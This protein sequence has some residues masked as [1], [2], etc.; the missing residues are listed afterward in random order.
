MARN[1]F[2]S[3]RFSDG[4]KYKEE[5]EKLFKDSEDV[6]NYSESEDRSNMSEDTIK[7]YLYG[8]LKNTSVTVILIT[9]NAISHQKNWLGQYDD[10]MYDEIRYSLEDRENNRCNG[11]VA[12]Y[13]DEVK[14]LLITKNTHKCNVCNKETTISSIADV[15]NLFRKN[16]MNVK[17][18]YKTNKCPDVYDSDKDSYCSLVSWDTFITGGNF[19]EYIEKAAQK[20]G[21]VHKYVPVKKL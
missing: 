2:V 15:D 4:A 20:R 11:I 14:D 13:T 7:K 5:L 6:I 18:E 10:W 17:D 19:S 16:M 9:P 1:V 21:E 12:V 8:K 3:F